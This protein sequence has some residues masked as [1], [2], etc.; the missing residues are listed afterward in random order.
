MD[1]L[2]LNVPAAAGIGHP[3]F[4]HVDAWVFDLDNTL[5]PAQC[6]LFAQIDDRMGAF[7]AR[8]LGVD[9]AEARR[10]QKQY[11][12]DHG[13]TLA[14]LM[15]VHGMKPEPFLDFVHDIDLAP[16]EA[17]PTL[18]AALARLP[19]KRFI[20][21]N[22]SV[23]HAENVAAKLGVLDRFDGIIDIAACGFVPKPQ[24]AAFE[25]FLGHSRAEAGRAAMFEDIARNLEVPHRLGMR[26]VWV[27]TQADFATEKA[28][29]GADGDHIHHVTDDLVAFLGAL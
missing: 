16:V 19:G 25:R 10:I 9:R 20:F 27:R 3:D 8:T 18:D 2:P 12:V 26:T 29:Y 1:T 5:Y 15:A 21:T 6:N 22:G 17:S 11:Y 7:I 4:H 28:H 24:A 23:R 14:G 13:T